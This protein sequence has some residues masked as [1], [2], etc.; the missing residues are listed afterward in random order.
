M[1]GNGDALDTIRSRADSAGMSFRRHLD[2]I[3]H[4]VDL[5]EWRSRAGTMELF[6]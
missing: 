1:S 6:W 4:A 2:L 5:S 3:R